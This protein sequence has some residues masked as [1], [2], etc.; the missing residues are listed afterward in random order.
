MLV[1]EGATSETTDPDVFITLLQ[2]FGAYFEDDVGAFRR[3]VDLPNELRFRIYDYYFETEDNSATCLSWPQFHLTQG[4]NSTALKADTVAFLP[5]IC[6]V[7]RVTGKEA[8]EHLVTIS[9]VVISH[10]RTSHGRSEL[11]SL[12]RLDAICRRLDVSLQHNIQAILATDVNKQRE[13][14]LQAQHGG[15]GAAGIPLFADTAI[16][17]NIHL[18]NTLMS[19]Y[20]D[21]LRKLDLTFFT[22]RCQGKIYGDGQ[23]TAGKCRTAPITHF[24]QGFGM[25]AVLRLKKLQRLM[26]T[27]RTHSSWNKEDD[28]AL[29]DTDEQLY[30]VARLGYEIKAGFRSKGQNV[31]IHTSLM[32]KDQCDEEILD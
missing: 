29:D 13:E 28:Q 32:Y 8:T 2:D 26:L 30:A 21:N 23:I 15:L 7:D 20:F 1:S 11:S 22:P 27:G 6:L 17:A 19:S 3:F 24:I 16:N 18:T 14:C 5:P 10:G 25:H 4:S 12:V 9:H 31:T